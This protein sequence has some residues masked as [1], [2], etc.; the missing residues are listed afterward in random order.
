MKKSAVAVHTGFVALDRAIKSLRNGDLVCIASRPSM[1]KTAFAMNIAANIV[2]SKKPKPVLFV[3]LEVNRHKIMQRFI[4]SEAKVDLKD[5]GVGYF[6]RDRWRDLTSAAARFAESPLFVCDSPGMT[7]SRVRASSGQLIAQLRK[8]N[9]ELGLIVIDYLQLMRG[10]ARSVNRRHSGIARSLKCLARDLN[11]PVIIL[12]QVRRRG[13]NWL[14]GA[15]PRISDL[16]EFGAL[17]H[18]ADILAFIYREEYYHP[19]KP[20]LKG[21]AEIIVAKNVRGR[22]GTIR[23]RFKREYL[24]FSGLD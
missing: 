22:T 10:G 2:L 23:M 1:G 16:K 14:T 13:A 15:R 19:L 20:G 4:A 7:V 21:R 8:E 3:S 6:N 18:E 12:S 24:T 9:K 17:E 11:V 5:I